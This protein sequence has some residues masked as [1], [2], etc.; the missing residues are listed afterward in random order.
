MT[1]ET[2]NT[3]ATKT[4]KPRRWFRFRLRTLLIMLTLLSVPLGW[5]GW[6]LDQRRREKD[7]VAWIEGLDSQVNMSAS[8]SFMNKLLN[9][10]SWWEKTKDSWFGERVLKA[11]LTTMT[12]SD[13]SP[14]AKLKKLK[15][16]RLDHTQVSDL[17][18]LAELKNLEHLH[19]GSTEVSDLSPLAELKRLKWLRLPCTQVSDLSPLAEL[20]NLEKLVLDDTEVSD[21]SPLADLQNL[22]ILDLFNT[23]VSEEQ[24][25]ELQK[26][27]PNCEISF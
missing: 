5:V 17:A 16:L 20:K 19:F 22:K 4:T 6:E 8:V 1:I 7:V 15:R 23:Q 26:A 14:L 21:L 9:E 18:P 12:V 10:R 2:H 27:L 13:I 11:Y 24:V 3:N 25:Q